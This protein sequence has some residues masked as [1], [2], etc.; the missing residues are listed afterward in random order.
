MVVGGRLLCNK[1]GA[2][3]MFG[4]SEIA[5][6]VSIVSVVLSTYF[7]AKNSKKT[8]VKELEER[9][10]QNT[11]INLKLDEINRIVKDSQSELATINND[12]RSLTERMIR[13]ESRARSNTHRL[14]AIDGIKE[15]EDKE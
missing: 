4:I 12:V 13:V 10:K 8:D 3:L 15:G 6:A 2:Y 14:D 5:L 9:V 11:T 1:E 7:S